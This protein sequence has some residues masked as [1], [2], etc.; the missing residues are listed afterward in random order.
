MKRVSF[1]EL[2]EIIKNALITKGY[3][4]EKAEISATL[5]AKSSLDGVYSHGLN[6]VPRLLDY[7]DKGL[8]KVNEEP[9]LIESMSL[10]ERYN[11]NLGPGDLNARYCMDQAISLAKNN[12]LGVVALQ[13]TNHWMRGG[14]YG[15]QAV[16]SGIMG[17]CWTNTES[18]MPPWGGRE[19]KLGNNPLII[20]IPHEEKPIVLDIA[21]S[22]YSYGKLQVT[23]L[24]NETLPFVGGY[25]SE[26]DL[27]HVPGEIEE[28]R[29]I[30]PTGLWKGSGLSL[31]LDIIAGLL[32]KGN[33]TAEIDKNKPEEGISCYGVSQVFIAVD[34]NKVSDK[35][36]VEQ[37]MESAIKHMKD[38]ALSEESQSVSYPGENTLQRRKENTEKGIP[39]NEDIL[40]SIIGLS[41]KN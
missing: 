37:V 10:L 35:E 23:R 5:F 4:N 24:N 11:G 31:V 41:N 2:K 26:G 30:L 33:I 22:Q 40:N 21:M 8:V 3:S 13:N 6:R 7:I 38:S 16:E 17:I 19:Q 14:N 34:I 12:T 29:R 9:T 39:V 36:S 20:S 25:N 1:Q 18:S 27:T 15:W 32:S 28:T